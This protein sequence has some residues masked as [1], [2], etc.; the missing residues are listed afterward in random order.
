MK[1]LNVAKKDACMACKACEVACSEAFYKE[2][3][4]EYSCIHIDV[5]KDGV[6]PKPVNCV[7]CGKCAAACPEGAITQNAKGVYMI[8]KKK[9][10]GCGKC[11]RECPASVITWEE[12]A[13]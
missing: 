11:V 3:K 6:T 10:I 2:Y 1:R 7:Q 8:N 9:C 13:K 5:K 4:E 12:A